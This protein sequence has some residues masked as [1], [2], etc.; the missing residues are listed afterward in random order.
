MKNKMRKITIL[1]SI[2]LHILILLLFQID[3]INILNPRISEKQKAVEDRLVFELVETPDDAEEQAPEENS[4]YVS[5][6][7]TKAADQRE[8]QLPEIENP[9]QQGLVDIPEFARQ[10]PPEEQQE[11][12]PEE[13][14]DVAQILSEMQQNK[15]SFLET[16]EAKKEMQV[17]NDQTADYENL[18][19]EV[20]DHGGMSLNTYQWEFA[21]YL[22]EMK[23]KVQAHNNPPF[24]FTHLGAID[25]DILLR[26][27]VLQDGTVQD[28]EIL[29]ST[30]HYSLENSSTRAIQFSAPFKPLPENFPKEY[31]EITA[32]FSYILRKK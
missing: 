21:P 12:E 19:S 29:K 32:L 26:F 10:N 4:D 31:L 7:N 5:D 24:A 15:K 18:L 8:N 3:E 20:K 30:A 11:N 6:K 2:L 14:N 17:L 27:K 9:Y 13:Q 28:L 1:I 25:G 16:Y 22:L 23:R